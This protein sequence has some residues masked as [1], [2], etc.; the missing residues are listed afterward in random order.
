MSTRE[1]ATYQLGIMCEDASLFQPN[2]SLPSKVCISV[3]EEHDFHYCPRGTP[4]VPDLEPMLYLQH[5]AY[6]AANSLHH[7]RSESNRRL[8]QCGQ[9][10]RV[11]WTKM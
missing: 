6:Q 4:N 7:G 10:W 9:L 8:A 11:F 1:T 5:C 2:D 3:E